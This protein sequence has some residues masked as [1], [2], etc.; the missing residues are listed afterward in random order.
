MNNNRRNPIQVLNE[1]YLKEFLDGRSL[2]SSALFSSGKCNSNYKLTLDDGTE[3]VARVSS[4][5]SS[6]RELHVMDLARELVKVP[7]VLYE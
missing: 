4:S 3:V 6:L 1:T 7:E 2:V 5:D